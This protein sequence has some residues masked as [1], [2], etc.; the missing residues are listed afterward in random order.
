MPL[1][2]Q[3]NDID[4][5]VILDDSVLVLCICIS[6]SQY[7]LTITTHDYPDDISECRFCGSNDIDMIPDMI[8][9]HNKTFE[10][11]ESS[12]HGK[13]S[14]F[15]RIIILDIHCVHCDYH[16]TVGLATAENGS[17]EIIFNFDH[18]YGSE[19]ARRMTIASYYDFYDIQWQNKNSRFNLEDK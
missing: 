6:K 2:H 1:T 9:G 17:R 10:E 11:R 14:S 3:F 4:E 16:G 19:I 13:L 18:S 15:K 5:A 12:K 7:F 8:L